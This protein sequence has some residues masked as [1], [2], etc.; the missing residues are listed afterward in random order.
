MTKDIDIELIAPHSIGQEELILTDLNSVTFAGRRWGKTE[1]GVQ[2]IYKSAFDKPGIYWWVGLTWRSASMKRAWRIIKEIARAMYRA[3]GEDP[4]DYIRE[5]DKEVRLPNGAEIWM[6]SAERPEA[7]AGEGIMGVVLDEFSLMK[8]M[9]WVEY[10]EASLLDNK[11]W[12]MFIGVPKGEN[13]A[14]LLWRKAAGRAGWIQRNYST[15]ENPFLESKR[16][17][18]IRANTPERWFMQEYLAKVID[19]AGGVF[20]RVS[21]AATAI[22]QHEAIKAKPASN[23]SKEEAA[24][25]YVFGVDW[26]QQHDFTVI[27]V[28]DLALRHVVHQDRFNKIDYIIQSERLKM[29]AKRFNPVTIIAEANSMGAP[30]IERLRNDGLDVRPFYTTNSTKEQIIRDLQTAFEIGEIKIIPDDTLIG[31]LQAYEQQQTPS[32]NWKFSAPDGMHDDCVM[33]LALAWHAAKRS[34][35]IILF[36]V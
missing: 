13:W 4:S 23:G 5:V 27:S 29:L 15:Y 14:A 9:V 17:D 36:S 33:A 22:E 10:V 12:A 32:N 19:D 26:G 34:E 11:G 21:E 7:L 3:I 1:A 35:P 28:V 25:Q 18:E 8:E 2:R 6:R 30:I 20:R 16:I 31:E 24:H